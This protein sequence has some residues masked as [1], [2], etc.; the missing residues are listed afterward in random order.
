MNHLQKWVLQEMIKHLQE[1]IKHLQGREGQSC[2][3]C[4]LAFKLFENENV[5][6]SYTCNAYESRQWIKEYWDYL[7]EI[8]EDYEYEYGELPVNPF[9][10]EEI[11]QM[12]I[13][14]HMASSLV[15]ESDYVSEKWNEEIEFTSD[16]I[17]K[18]VS[19]WSE[20]L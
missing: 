1:M 10:S 9:D 6:G 5:T 12:Q 4:D 14:L 15:V 18:I 3:G 7:G 17:E 2:Y 16:I 20:C 11:F 8:V 13:I 19:E